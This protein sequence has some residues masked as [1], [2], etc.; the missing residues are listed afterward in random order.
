MY[1]YALQI[2]RSLPKESVPHPDPAYL[3][4]PTDIIKRA[5]KLAKKCRA[6]KVTDVELTPALRSLTEELLRQDERFMDFTQAQALQ[7]LG[8]GTLTIANRQ[9]RITWFQLT[10]PLFREN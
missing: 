4:S 1:Y 3:H 7:A 2:Y 9:H 6:G 5:L 8:R 10:K